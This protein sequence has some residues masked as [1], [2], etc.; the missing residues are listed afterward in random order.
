MPRFI[1]VTEKEAQ[2]T[3]VRRCYNMEVFVRAERPRFAYY[4]HRYNQRLEDYDTKM[5]QFSYCRNC[6]F[7][8][9]TVLDRFGVTSEPVRNMRALLPMSLMP[10]TSYTHGSLVGD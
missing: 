10:P 6:R 5:G 7:W 9:S 2:P 4:C 1:N 8:K 3:P